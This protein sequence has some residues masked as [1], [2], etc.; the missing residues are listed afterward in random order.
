MAAVFII[1]LW[2]VLRMSLE[3]SGRG[4][5]LSGEELLIPP[6]ARAAGV[7]EAAKP[8]KDREVNQGQQTKT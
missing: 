3:S 8:G 5:S 6:Q 4:G 7:T 1:H 2:L